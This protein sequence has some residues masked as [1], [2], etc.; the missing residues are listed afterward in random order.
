MKALDGP[1]KKIAAGPGLVGV[2]LYLVDSLTIEIPT[3]KTTGS[4]RKH[5]LEPILISR[6]TYLSSQL[7]DDF[8]RFNILVQVAKI[9][10]SRSTV[11]RERLG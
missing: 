3:S 8:V 7:L 11:S 1:V 10:C 4:G 6:T 2:T 9:I 5:Q